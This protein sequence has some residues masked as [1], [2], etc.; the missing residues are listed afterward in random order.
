MIDIVPSDWKDLQKKVCQIFRDIGFDADVG[1]QVE[2]ANNSTAEVDVFAI[3][4]L[5]SPPIS[6][7]CECKRWKNKVPRSVV[8]SFKM[9]VSEQGANVGLIISEKGAQKGAFESVEKTNIKLITWLE[10]QAMFEEKWWSK[11]TKTLYVNSQDFLSFADPLNNESL[12]VDF[13][14]KCSRKQ[15]KERISRNTINEFKIIRK[16][17][18]TIA[19]LVSD[20]YL[21]MCLGNDSKPLLPYVINIPVVGLEDADN[22]KINSLREYIESLTIG[23][24]RGLQEFGSLIR[25]P[26]I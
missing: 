10:F 3:D 18:S 6:Y 25:K 22:R 15:G 23:V 9:D 8:Q 26:A 14:R 17:Y 16:K 24:N 4:T 5:N 2:L 12:S 7:Y 20:S 19:N 11:V 1:C 13:F 21:E